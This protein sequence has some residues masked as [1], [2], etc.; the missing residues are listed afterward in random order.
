MFKFLPASKLMNKL[1]FAFLLVALVPL[2]SMGVFNYS[3]SKAALKREILSGLE[4]VAYGAIDK[5]GQAMHR[6]YIDVQEWAELDVLYAALVYDWGVRTDALFSHL[7]KKN[8]LYKAIVLFDK[9][10][11]LFS[12][13]DSSFRDKPES[14]QRAEFDREY[15]EGSKEGGPVSVRDFRYS[16]LV[17][18]YTVSFSSLVKD[19]EAKPIGIVT[20]F[21][22]WT[23][24]QEFATGEH[25]LPVSKSEVMRA[26]LVCCWAPMERPSLLITILLLSAYRSGTYCR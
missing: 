4:V 14:A 19:L 7:T 12:T 15:L 16:D 25:S 10:G 11:K 17:D 18:D 2:V 6:S 24:I 3:R 9:E 22:D 5:I 23:V 1:F 21:I 26:G 20:L 13:S 8:R